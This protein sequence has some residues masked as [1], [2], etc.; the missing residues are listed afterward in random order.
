MDSV[1]GW[2]VEERAVK[3]D[4]AQGGGEVG[5]WEGAQSVRSEIQWEELKETMEWKDGRAQGC[6]LVGGKS[7]HRA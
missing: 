5:Q 1:R 2:P 3:E 6:S 7:L 4:S